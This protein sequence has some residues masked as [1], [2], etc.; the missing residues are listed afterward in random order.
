MPQKFEIRADYDRETIV[1][2]QAYNKQIALPAIEQNR[3]I[4]P[5]SF[6]RMTWIKPS[7]LWLMER[8][9]WGQKSNQEYILAIR[10]K[11]VAWE[12]ALSLGVLSSPESRVYQSGEE[13]EA[14]KADAPVQLQWDP[15]RSLRGKK[16]AYRSIQ[17][18]IGRTL[19]EE[20]VN[21]WITEIQDYT[22]L[23]RKIHKLCITGM[24]DKAKRQLPQEKVY[25]LSP[26]LKKIIGA[27]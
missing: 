26:E 6:R 12:K 19:I 23:T 21:D 18:G 3:F 17:V 14:K 1:V 7:F 9:N 5:F 16:L 27:D 2:Y 13:W 15:E 24:H 25:P 10:I 4:S 22:P 8:S 11:R 20:F